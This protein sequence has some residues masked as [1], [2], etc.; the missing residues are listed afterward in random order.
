MKNEELKQHTV[1]VLIFGILLS[2]AIG[3]ISGIIFENKNIKSI[4][5]CMDEQISIRVHYYFGCIENCRADKDVGAYDG[6]F[7][8]ECAQPC[9]KKSV[10]W[11]QDWVEQM[12]NAN[13]CSGK[14]RG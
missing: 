7:Q 1:K 8:I 2:L 13:K 10:I 9:F 12:Y 5:K 4:P 6:K 3:F 14:A 11:A